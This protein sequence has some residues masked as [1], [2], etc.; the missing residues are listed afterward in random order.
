MT[1]YLDDI[2]MFSKNVNKQLQHLRL[3]FEWL[4]KEKFMAKQQKCEF[5]KTCIKYLGHVVEN[6]TVYADPDKVSMLQT[7][8]NLKISKKCSSLWDW[9]ITMR[10]TFVIL[11]ILLHCS[12]L[13]CLLSGNGFGVPTMIW[14]LI[15]Y[16]GSY[17]THLCYVCL[18]YYIVL[19]WIQMHV[20]MPLGLYYCRNIVMGIILWL[21]TLQSKTWPN[22]T[23]AQGTRSCL[24]WTMDV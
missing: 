24:C 10:K 23:M 13:W 18:T 11:L 19:S 8:L 12:R 7:W 4:H 1:V 15:S 16:G 6:R 21:S 20:S 5:G 14:H 17:V 3:V 2:L 22:I 9:L